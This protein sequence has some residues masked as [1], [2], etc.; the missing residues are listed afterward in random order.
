MLEFFK[1]QAQRAVDLVEPVFHVLLDLAHGLFEIVLANIDF[2]Q[3]TLNLS[4]VL[5]QVFDR[6]P[7]DFQNP[8]P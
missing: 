3:V 2:R 1:D 4:D 6:V 5:L 7:D 8:A